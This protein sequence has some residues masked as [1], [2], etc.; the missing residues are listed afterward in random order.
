MEKLMALH[1]G[2]GEANQSRK[3]FDAAI[4]AAKSE[5]PVINKNRQVGFAHKTRQRQHRILA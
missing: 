5:I 1:A 3:A 4:S 2:A